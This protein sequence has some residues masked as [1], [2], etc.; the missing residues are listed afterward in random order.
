MKENYTGAKISKTRCL[1]LMGRMECNIPGR[2]EESKV[3]RLLSLTNSKLVLNFGNL[4]L[5]FV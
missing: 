4:K 2:E 1:K 5:F 3:L